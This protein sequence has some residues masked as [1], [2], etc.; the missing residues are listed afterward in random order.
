MLE[1]DVEEDVKKYAEK[2]GC[3]T[4]KLN[5]EMNRGKPDRLFFYKGRTLVIE[6]K[7]PGGKATELQQSWLTK[8][9]ANGF[10][11]HVVDRIGDGKTYIDQFIARTET[12]N[13][14]A[15]LYDDL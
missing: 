14:L 8:F 10:T 9:E 12:A 1:K 11:T 3:M 13:K 7:K 4:I 5:G 2:R 6:F 15:E